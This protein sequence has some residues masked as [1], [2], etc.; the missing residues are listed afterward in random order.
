MTIVRP[1]IV[2]G[3]N[4]DNYLVRLWT[5]QPFAA[6][7][8]DTLDNEIQFVHEDDVVE[9]ITG[10][11]V[12][13]H[14][15]AYNVAGDGLMTMR[16]CAELI[17]VA[18]PQAA[19][20]RLPRPG[21]RDVGGARPKPR[22]ARSTSPAIRGWSRPTSSSGRRAGRRSFSSRETF[23]ITMR[24]HGKMPPAKTPS[25][26]VPLLRWPP[27]LPGP[28]AQL[29]ERRLDKPE[30]AGSSPA[31]PIP[32]H[33]QISARGA[34]HQSPWGSDGEVLNPLEAARDRWRLPQGLP[35]NG[36]SSGS[37][38]ALPVSL[39]Y[40]FSSK[41]AVGPVTGSGAGRTRRRSSRPRDAKRHGVRTRLTPPWQGVQWR[42][43]P[44]VSANAIASS[45]LIWAPAV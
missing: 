15:G 14:G 16:E 35:Q 28:L 32:I 9:A 29:G 19:A 44:A 10:L 30:V 4:V 41:A 5:K 33:S 13:R 3:P 18:G 31:R 20:A 1:C 45:K 11:L 8:E 25:G 36:S 6:D 43:W 24:A 40:R 23:E 34:A 27:D 42:V 37:S 26:P 17:G 7:V 38:G 2:F 12:G 22:P 39:R 21:P